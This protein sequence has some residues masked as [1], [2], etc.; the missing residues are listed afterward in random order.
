M[1]A[2]LLLTPAICFWW[3]SKHFWRLWQGAEQ[4]RHLTLGL[5]ISQVADNP[6]ALQAYREH[7]LSYRVMGSDPNYL[8]GFHGDKKELELQLK[9]MRSVVSETV[10]CL[11]MVNR[12][13]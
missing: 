1:W 6:E 12:S 9:V 7:L 4:E 3:R 5:L 13:S 8:D 11:S 2:L 10:R